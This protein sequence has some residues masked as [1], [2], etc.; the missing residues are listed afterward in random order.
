M[1]YRK[2]GK[3]Q[4]EKSLAAGGMG[5][6]IKSVDDSGQVFALKKI[7]KEYQDDPQFRELFRREAEITFALDHP[8]IVRVKG[9]DRV[10]HQLVLV[11]EYLEGVDLRAL[12]SKLF[13]EKRTMP[14]V[15]AIEVI[16]RVL[17]GLQYAH[18][19]R[20]KFGKSLGIIHRDLSP[21][22]IFFTF[23]G[24]IKILDFGISKAT[25]KSVHNLTPK[26]ELRGKIAYLAPE[27]L[28]DGE[29]DLRADVFSVGILLWEL[30]ATQPLFPRESVSKTFEAILGGHYTSV[31]SFRQ[32][33][34]ME[35]DEIL[36]KA[37]RVNREE[38]FQTAG[39][40]EAALTASLR[41]HYPANCG[42]KELSVYVKS[43]FQPQ[44]FE[45]ADSLHLAGYGWL[46]TQIPGFQKKGFDL[47]QKIALENPTVPYAQLCY[48]RAL[49][50]VGRRQES[51]R[52]LR[53]L[54]RVDSLEKDVEDLLVWLGVRRSPILAFLPRS[55]P[56]NHA[57]GKIRHRLLGPTPFQQEFASA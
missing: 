57:L 56:I 31:G 20:D 12:L 50:S 37:L 9:F 18:S 22:N 36:R 16:R 33:I 19:K 30:L 47:V 49:L 1:E 51:M 27:Q 54:A 4:L 46:M 43:L 40:F 52:L 10:G 42:S 21:S 53:R 14:V 55:N 24:E 45:S 29:I 17:R 32:D 8:N 15:V 7:L 25:E 48:V 38:R 6:V 23:D 13:D 5:E 44:T 11:L 35:V 41:S 2:L 26:G 28:K 3:F 34:P 39:D